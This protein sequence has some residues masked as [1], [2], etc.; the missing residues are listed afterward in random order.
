MRKYKEDVS[1][2]A[3]I[4]AMMNRI[5]GKRILSQNWGTLTAYDVLI[6][7]AD[8]SQE[9]ALR[10]M[11]DSGDGVAII[12]YNTLKNTVVLIRQFRLSAYIRAIDEGII[13]EVPA[14][15][16]E[17]A[18][19]EERV[20]AETFEE[21]GYRIQEVELVAKN[22]ASPGAHM[23]YMYLYIAEVRDEMKEGLGGGLAE[24]G[25][26]IEVVEINFIKALQFLKEGII[27]DAKTIILLQ[28]LCLHHERLG[29][30][31]H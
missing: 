3:D 23:E 20:R 19:P 25:E 2:F 7:Q 5:Q 4:N 6:D 18:N 26:N 14:G 13:Y 21:T 9:L 31:A 29:L 28:Y 24:E 30:R 8:G 1:T 10:E 16:L 27:Q 15:L 12:L 17:G 11:Y 22:F